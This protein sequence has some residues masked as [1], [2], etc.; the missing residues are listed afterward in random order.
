MDFG[1]TH[2]IRGNDFNICEH[3]SNS[4]TWVH[5]DMNFE[6]KAAWNMLTLNARF[7]DSWHFDNFSQTSNKAYTFDNGHQRLGSSLF[8][9]DRIYESNRLE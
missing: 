9:L 4:I 6:E 7:I 5:H 1:A 2:V 8:R 3:A